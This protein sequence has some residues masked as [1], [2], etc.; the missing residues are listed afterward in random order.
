MARRAPANQFINDSV[1]NAVW[2]TGFVTQEFATTHVGAGFK[3][4]LSW[5]AFAALPGMAFELVCK[6]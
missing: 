1:K 4:A 3:P 6:P 5:I 2:P